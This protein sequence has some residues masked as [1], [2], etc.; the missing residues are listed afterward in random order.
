M[1][2]LIYTGPNGHTATL[3]TNSSASHYGVPAL[4]CAARLLAVARH[5][6]RF[7]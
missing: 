5:R 6:R 4:R 7:A 2:L 3:T 1:N